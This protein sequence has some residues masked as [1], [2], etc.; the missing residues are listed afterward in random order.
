MHPEKN[1]VDFIMAAQD[2]ER[3]ARAFAEAK[4]GPALK[5]LFTANDFTAITDQECTSLAYA[6]SRIQPMVDAAVA[7]PPPSPKY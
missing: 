4:D 3:L 6:K 5:L 7:A 1:F 2:D